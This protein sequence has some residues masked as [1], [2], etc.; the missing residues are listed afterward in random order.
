[1]ETNINE[2]GFDQEEWKKVQPQLEKAWDECAAAGK[3]FEDFVKLAAEIL[4]PE[5]KAYYRKFVEEVSK[6]AVPRVT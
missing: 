1:M 3:P 5:G 6:E 2:N 4:G